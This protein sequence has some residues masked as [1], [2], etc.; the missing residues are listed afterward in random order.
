M[1]KKKFGLRISIGFILLIVGSFTISC[2]DKSATETSSE[3]YEKEI[4][5]SNY[6]FFPDS[7]PEDAENTD[8]FY[9]PGFWLAKSKAYVNFET[10]EE[11]LDE[12]EL[13]YG[14]D[15]EEVTSTD[16]WRERHIENDKICEYIKDNYLNNDSCNIYVKAEG[17]S[18]QGY[19][20]DRDENEIFIF[21]DGFD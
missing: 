4:N 9:S 14:Q 8:F 20:I 10:T 6:E 17:F 11:Y 15:V 18:I 12:Y 1:K 7:L 19:A 13:K 5:G 16:V 21:Y 3:K 2:A